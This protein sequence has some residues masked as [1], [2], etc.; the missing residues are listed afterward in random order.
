MNT[1]V[2]SLVLDFYFFSETR[3]LPGKAYLNAFL[4]AMRLEPKALLISEYPLLPTPASGTN[5]SG[6]FF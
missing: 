6:H 5:G 3:F 1:M 4:K 2:Y